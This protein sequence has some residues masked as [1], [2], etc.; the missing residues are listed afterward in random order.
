[1]KINVYIQG[2]GFAAKIDLPQVPAIG[3][4]VK[5]RRDDNR[6]SWSYESEIY[7]GIVDV[8]MWDAASVLVVSISLREPTTS[9]GSF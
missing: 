3:D 1:M 8:V 6:K 7:F 5:I 4:L 9:E 2:S